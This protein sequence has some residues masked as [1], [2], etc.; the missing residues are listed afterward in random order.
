MK[1]I[2]LTLMCL[3]F[4]PLFAEKRIQ[5]TEYDLNYNP[6][7]R[8]YVSKNIYEQKGKILYIVC[9]VESG[10]YIGVQLFS[11]YVDGRNIAKSLPDSSIE[12]NGK[13]FTF[14]I[15]KITGSITTWT[16]N[17]LSFFDIYKHFNLFYDR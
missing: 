16:K 3:L 11:N 13:K 7:Y 9:T 14:M 4:I 1:C 10:P 15:M 6:D 17:S 8:G 5:S 12:R 2:F